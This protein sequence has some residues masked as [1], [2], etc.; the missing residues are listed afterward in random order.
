MALNVGLAAAFGIVGLGFMVGP[1]L[2]R[3]SADLSEE[4]EARV[5]S[6]ERAD[7][8]AHL[9]DSVLQTLA[10][11]Q[12]SAGDATTVS[13]LARAQERD[14]RSWLF[15]EDGEGPAT[16][17]PALRAVAAEV[18]DAHGVPVEVVC[19][20]DMPI[21]DDDRPLVLA[22]RE[23]ITNAAKH[24]GRAPSTSTPRRLRPVSR[25]SCATGAQGSTLTGSRT[26][27]TASAAAS[28]DGCN[29]TEATRRC[30]VRRGGHRGP[31]VPAV[32]LT[33][34]PGST[35]GVLMSPRTVVIVD[36]HAMF[37]TGVR[38]ELGSSVDV[39]A[40]AADVDQAV[41]AVLE[42]QPEVVLLDVHLPGG[43]GPR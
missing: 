19:V 5:R 30:G 13:R 34:P 29:A 31:A 40:E 36:D 37:R 10:L 2:F 8:A 22:T 38:A 9:H 41:A 23:A 33:E 7:V 6:E 17:A 42:H 14:L 24:S 25:S 26:T 21:T 15:E 11:I 1:W 20:G 16:L 27:A 28:S 39:V 32:Q 12:R 4:R 35:E 3:L 43:G 18:E